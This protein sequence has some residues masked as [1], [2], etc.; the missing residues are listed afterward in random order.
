P[1]HRDRLLDPFFTTKPVGEGTGL[2]LS[3]CHSILQAHHATLEIESEYGRGAAFRMTFPPLSQPDTSDEKAK[4]E[5]KV[6]P[7]ADTGTPEPT[8]SGR[9]PR[10][11]V[12]VLDD[13]PFVRSLFEEMLV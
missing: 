1:E 12:A 8:G 9:L 11:H 13:E 2:G 7:P 10:L 6:G 3:I 5:G 4:S